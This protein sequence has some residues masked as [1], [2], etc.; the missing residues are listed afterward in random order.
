VTPVGAHAWVR[1]QTV[2]VVDG[3][4]VWGGF[5]RQAIATYQWMFTN[6]PTDAQ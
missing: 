4:K 2:A 3:P 6:V 5:W 1:G